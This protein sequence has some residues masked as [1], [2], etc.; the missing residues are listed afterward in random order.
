MGVAEAWTLL[1]LGL[2]VIGVRVYVRWTAVGPA[3][4]QLDDYLMPLTGLVFTAETVAAYLVGALFQGLT[5]SYMTDEE[6]AALDPNSE[7]YYNRQWGSKI[8]VIG[9]SF[10]AAILWMLKICIAVFY[11]R[12][13]SGLVHLRLRVRIAYVLLGTTYLVV[14]LCILLG[15]QPMHKYWQINPDPGNLCQPTNSK[16][17]VLVVLIPNIITDTYLLSI[18]LP[19]LWTV[20]IGWRRK[21]SLMLLFSGAVF[22]IMAGTIRAVV[23]ITSGPEGAVSGSE[24]ACRE[25]FV[26]IVVANLPIIQ[27]LIRRGASKLGLSGMFSKSTKMGRSHPLGSQDGNG[28]TYALTKHTALRTGDASSMAT[29]SRSKSQSRVGVTSRP[30]NP[31]ID[32]TIDQEVTIIHEE[33]DRKK[34]DNE[35]DDKIEYHSAISTNRGV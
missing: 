29:A 22:V 4:F 26:A 18:P 11:S 30:S 24:W 19:L 17:Y 7:E 31:R 35:S 13:T 12:L 25:T 28:D 5:N 16:L 3:K 20:N 32:I 8:Q 34:G 1:S 10:Y 14:A 6:R 2:A 33:I 27:P 15:C 9:W 21:A 23:I